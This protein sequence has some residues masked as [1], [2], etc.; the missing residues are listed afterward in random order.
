MKHHQPSAK[1]TAVDLKLTVWFLVHERCLAC[2]GKAQ[3]VC[4][5]VERLG[6]D[7]SISGVHQ[8]GWLERG[9]GAWET[10]TPETAPST[11]TK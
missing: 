9:A 2:E 4:T 5:K 6:L 10:A 1:G 7:P 11:I 8:R 3:S